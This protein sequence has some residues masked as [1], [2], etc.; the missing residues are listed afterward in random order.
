MCGV[1]PLRPIDR[2][3]A[4]VYAQHYG[5]PTGACAFADALRATGT[6]LMTNGVYR[7]GT[8]AHNV[9]GDIVR[10]QSDVDTR[11]QLQ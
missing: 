4:N 2:V 11:E 5:P 1:C 8:F 10:R 6:R 7:D 9:L 3:L